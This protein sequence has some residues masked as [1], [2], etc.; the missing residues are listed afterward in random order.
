MCFYTLC[1]LSNHI[2][3]NKSDISLA[4]FSP[5][6]AKTNVGSGGK[7]NG[8]LMASCVN[9][10]HTKNYGNLIICFQVTVEN[11]RN[12]FLAHSARAPFIAHVSKT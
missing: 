9:N 8:H 11:A 5:G 2:A 10:I 3:L 6:S 12:V 1:Y 7:L 4:V